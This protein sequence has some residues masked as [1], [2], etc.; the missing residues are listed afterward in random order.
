MRL[1]NGEVLLHWPL[2]QHILTHGWKYNNSNKH[3]GVVVAIFS[4]K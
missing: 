1:Q 2:D 4:L 3:N